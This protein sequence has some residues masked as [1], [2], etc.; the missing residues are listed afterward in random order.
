MEST[1]GIWR[2]LDGG[3]ATNQWRFYCAQQVP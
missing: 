2:L 1:N 3:A